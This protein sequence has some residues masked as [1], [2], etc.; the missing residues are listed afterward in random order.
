MKYISYSYKGKLSYGCLIGDEIIPITEILDHPPETLLGLIELGIEIQEVSSKKMIPLRDVSVSSPITTPKRNLFCLGKNYDDHVGEIKDVKGLNAS[1]PDYPVYFSKIADPII[2]HKD[3]ILSHSN[4]TNSIDYEVELAVII[5]KTCTC[6]DKED[7][8]DHIFGLTIAND[9]SA[10]DLQIK[11]E[12]WLMGKSL[13][14]FCSMGPVIVSMDEFDLPLELGLSCFVNK[15]KRQHSNTKHMIFDIP[16]ILSEM[17]KI[18]TLNPGDIILT[19]TPA[20]VGLGYSPP[21]YLKTGDVVTCKI[22][23]IGELINTIK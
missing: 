2:G 8:Y 12:Q 7:A 1:R 23:K 13:P 20:G 6:I 14:T 19:G 16:S 17:S 5:G 21:K 3:D 4:L 22:D 10:R 9:V 15:E 11:H 18:I